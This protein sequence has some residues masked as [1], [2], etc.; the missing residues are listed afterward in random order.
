MR[1]DEDAPIGTFTRAQHARGA[2]LFV[3]RN[4]T[5]STRR[6]FFTL[7]R[8]ASCLRTVFEGFHHLAERDAKTL[9]EAWNLGL[10]RHQSTTFSTAVTTMFTRAN[11]IRTF[12]ARL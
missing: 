9:N 4:D 12:Q 10:G 6:D 8:I 2:V 1:L 11:G 7:V 3:Q 5:T